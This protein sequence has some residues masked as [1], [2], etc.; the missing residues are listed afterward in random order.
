MR[1]SGFLLCREMLFTDFLCYRG[2]AMGSYNDGLPEGEEGE[3]MWLGGQALAAAKHGVEVQFCMALAHQIL[4]SS[5]WPSVTNARV[6][7]DGGLDVVHLT[8][9]ALL[10]A[11]VGLGWSKDN[12]RTADKCYVPG[13]YR[14]HAA[15]HWPP[16]QTDCPQ[17]KITVC[18]HFS[19]WYCQVAMWFD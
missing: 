18:V 4:M 9:P 12:L 10:A 6:N 3:H 2:P 13:L 15:I 8:L 16:S 17:R 11:T 14:A 19:E 1:L 7:G 5:D